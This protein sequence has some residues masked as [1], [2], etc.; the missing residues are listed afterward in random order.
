MA[1]HG[2]GTSFPTF[3]EF[4]ADLQGRG[5]SFLEALAVELKGSGQFVARTLGE[6]FLFRRDFFF[7]LLSKQI[8]SGHSP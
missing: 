6:F 1:I 2:P 8:L 5:P 4:A 3:G 7:C